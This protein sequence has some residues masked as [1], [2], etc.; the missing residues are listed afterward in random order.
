MHPEQRSPEIRAQIGRV[1]LRSWDPVGVRGAPEDA[2]ERD[3]YVGGVY[4]LLVDGA[5]APDISRHLVGI[6]TE[7]LGFEDSDPRML[8]PLAR[9]LQR[10]YARL[11]ASY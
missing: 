7:Q 1:L 6:E 8:I 5:R 4:R 9:K 3:A 11:A 10:L 2:K